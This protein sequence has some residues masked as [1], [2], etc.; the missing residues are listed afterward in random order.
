MFMTFITEINLLIINTLPIAKGLFTRFMNNTGLPGTMSLLDYGL[1]DNEHAHTVTTF[2]IDEDA[3]FS[4]G[5]DHALLECDIV[6]GSHPHIK[7]DF[8]E[9]IQ[10]DFGEKTSFTEYQEHL[11]QACSSIS[12]PKFST[13]SSSDMLPHITESIHTSALKSFGLKTKKK[14]RGVRL[15]KTIINLIKTKNQLAQSIPTSRLQSSHQEMTKLLQQLETLKATIKNSISDHK[16]QKR[17]NL[18]SKLLIADPTRRRFWRF[19][20]SQIKSAG[21]ISAIYNQVYFYS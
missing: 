16:L 21:S 5:S 18:R 9:V 17:R 14:K 4:A 1:I 12:L 3:R 15:P 11:D 20:K 7:W 13:L 2:T 8:Q 6:F 10:Y 19:L